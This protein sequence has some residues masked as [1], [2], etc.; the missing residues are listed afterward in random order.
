MKKSTKWVLWILG[1]MLAVIFINFY[2]NQF[3]F[4]YAL[5]TVLLLVFTG[6]GFIVKL[7]NDVRQYEDHYRRESQS[8]I[9]DIEKYTR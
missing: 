1:L 8:R 4:A 9:D 6:W 2:M 5:I 3:S 7:K